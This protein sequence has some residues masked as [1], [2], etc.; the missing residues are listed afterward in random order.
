MHLLSEYIEVDLS[1]NG[2]AVVSQGKEERWREK[3]RRGRGGES[4][5][6]PAKTFT[7]WQAVIIK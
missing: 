4:I 6:I 5:C 2:Q 3:L 7:I 1:V